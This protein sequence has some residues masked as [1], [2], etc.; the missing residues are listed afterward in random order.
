MGD[1]NVAARIR[2]LTAL[3][4]AERRPPRPSRPTGNGRRAC[5]T[6]ILRPRRTWS[7]SSWT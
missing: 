4:M 1:A 3:A 2:A 5:S 6:S 7:T